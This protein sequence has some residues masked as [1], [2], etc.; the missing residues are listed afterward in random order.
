MN[1]TEESQRVPPLIRC[2]Q[3]SVVR[4]REGSPPAEDGRVVAPG[5]K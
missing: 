1:E 2:P 4:S 5:A 3:R